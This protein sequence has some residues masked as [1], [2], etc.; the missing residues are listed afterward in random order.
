M[1][2]THKL[3]TDPKP[4]SD[5]FIGVKGFEIRYDD[6]DY[7]VGDTLILMETK[8]S[9][10]DMRENGKPLNFTSR[11]VHQTVDYILRGPIYGLNSGWVI[12][13]VTT[14]RYEII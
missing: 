10:D 3:K 7:Q 6:R 13:G 1:S 14:F 9:G 11:Q 8:Y 2:K 5:S 4:F 12:L